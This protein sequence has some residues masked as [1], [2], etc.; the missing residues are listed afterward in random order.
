MTTPDELPEWERL[1]AAE[2]HLQTLVPEAILVGGTAAA[3]HAGHA[4]QPVDAAEIDLAS[5]RG[6]KA[7][8]NDWDYVA[9]HGRGWAAVLADMLLGEGEPE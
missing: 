3:L 8:W 6:L 5:Y 7:P 2:R 1:L 4:A 9:E